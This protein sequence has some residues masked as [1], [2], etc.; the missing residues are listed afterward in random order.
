[1]S[2][3]PLNEPFRGAMARKAKGLEAER[4]KSKE[5]AMLAPESAVVGDG[6]GS[7]KGKKRRE[8]E[9]RDERGGRGEVD[10]E[11]V[12]CAEAVGMR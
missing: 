1:M 11:G 4:Y 9:E 12:G 8:R 10:A 5:W 2:Q 6:G 3:P 7:G